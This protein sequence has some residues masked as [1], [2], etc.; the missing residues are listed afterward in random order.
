MNKNEF[1]KKLRIA[2]SLD[3]TDYQINNQIN[4]YDNYIDS[5]IK[6]GRTEQEVINELGDPNL[7]AKTIKQV[8]NDNEVSYDNNYYNNDYDNNTF[9]SDTY[10]ND[11]YNSNENKSY[12]PFGNRTYRQFSGG[13]LSCLI[14]SLVFF[15]VMYAILRFFGSLLY[16]GF[17]LIT[18]YP[19][20]VL[21]IILIIFLINKGRN[22]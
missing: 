10:G 4:Y 15:L 8:S 17:Y 21:V 19:I 7:I 3:L 20:A 6:K 2:L 16:G 11:N 1:L 5:E 9:N 18:Y 22:R 13:G 12:N 14:I